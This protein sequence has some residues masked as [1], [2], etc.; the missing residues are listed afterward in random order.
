[1]RYVKHCA[2]GSGLENNTARGEGEC[3]ITLETTTRAQYLRNMHEQTIHQLFYYARAPTLVVLSKENSITIATCSIFS[4]TYS[5]LSRCV[6]YTERC[7]DIRWFHTISLLVLVEKNKLSETQTH[8][9]SPT[10]NLQS[11]LQKWQTD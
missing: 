8:A 11:S 1:M 3:Y 9:S 7:F 6:L 4:M 5:L 2:R 10:Q